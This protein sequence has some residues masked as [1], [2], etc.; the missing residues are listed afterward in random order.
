M[1]WQS[2]CDCV[3]TFWTNPQYNVSISGGDT[4]DDTGCGSVVIA[5]MQ[6][7]RRQLRRE[8]KTDLT[9]GYAVYKVS[10]SVYLSIGLFFVAYQNLPGRCLVCK[11]GSHVINIRQADWSSMKNKQLTAT[12][13]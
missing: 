6:K 8:G 5:L 10:L 7:H 13:C 2:L 9:I 4:D 11:H 12:P 3:A 1:R